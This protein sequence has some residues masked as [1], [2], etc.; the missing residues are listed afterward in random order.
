MSHKHFEPNPD[1]AERHHAELVAA[2]ATLE[3]AG[4]AESET[5]AACRAVLVAVGRLRFQH[6][7]VDPA[8]LHVAM[9]T[10]ESTLESADWATYEDALAVVLD[11]E[12]RLVLGDQEGSAT[13][14]IA[15]A[16]TACDELECLLLG[17]EA[18][19]GRPP[20]LPLEAAI[21][22]AALELGLR[23]ELWRLAP[24]NLERARAVAWVHPAER[25]RLW[26]WWEALDLAPSVVD[27]LS[28]AAHAIRRYP[29]ARQHL[30]QLVRADARLAEMMQGTPADT[31]PPIHVVSLVEWIARRRALAARVAEPG[32]SNDIPSSDDV[33]ALA[34][35]FEGGEE[36]LLHDAC[37]EV[38]WAPPDQLLVDLLVAPHRHALPRLRL[39]GHDRVGT[40]VPDCEDRYVF[41]LSSDD[42]Q[43]H[44]AEL[45]I[46][47]AEGDRLLPLLRQHEH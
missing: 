13:Q 21:H 4:R 14:A 28:A 35:G 12:P 22:R 40:A 24:M 11:H 1:L 6:L 5:R 41:V 42:L 47:L 2:L 34:M 32:N 33:L 25:P 44:D 20:E 36:L 19:L 39:D 16:L 3:S 29:S 46:P 43:S 10:I 37:V 30:E 23:P 27:A 8:A 31:A 45:V 15:A 38:S 17:A 18:L 26:W 9:A 7:E